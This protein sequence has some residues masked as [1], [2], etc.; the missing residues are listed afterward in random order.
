MEA[1][2]R[3]AC[4]RPGSSPDNSSQP[5]GLVGSRGV[6]GNTGAL[7]AAATAVAG[8]SKLP[9]G[10]PILLNLSCATLLKRPYGLEA[11]WCLAVQFGKTEAGAGMSR[12]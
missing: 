8:W 5:L 4:T 3:S 12:R 2:A 7:V 1:A 11:Q 6:F 9:G 10:G